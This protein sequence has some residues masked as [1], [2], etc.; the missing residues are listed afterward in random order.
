MEGDAGGAV[1]RACGNE[2]LAGQG[3]RNVGLFPPDEDAAEAGAH[4]IEPSGE[5]PSFLAVLCC[6]TS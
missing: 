1:E 6:I 3:G 2:L 5:S 4:G